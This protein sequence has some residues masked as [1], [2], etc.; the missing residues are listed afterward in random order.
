MLV[1]VLPHVWG[2]SLHTCHCSVFVNKFCVYS[3]PGTLL[4]FFFLKKNKKIFI[5]FF[6]IVIT[7]LLVRWEDAV[8]PTLHI[9]TEIA[10]SSYEKH[11]DSCH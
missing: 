7:L 4:F 2:I 5:T 9:F 11:P 3:V 1:S 6:K 8:V 10:I